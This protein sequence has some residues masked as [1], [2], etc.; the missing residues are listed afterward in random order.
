MSNVV[1][2][3]LKLDSEKFES[4]KKQVE[5]KRLSALAGE[6]VVFEIAGLTQS[7]FEEIQEMCTSIDFA[8][9]E[10]NV[11]F[12]KMQLESLL[13]GVVSPDLKNP[14]LMKR[15]G[16]VTPYDFIKKFLTPG[17]IS[18][19]YEAISDLS[20]FGTDAIEDVKKQ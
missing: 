11:D 17:E 16:S 14:E 8:T 15:F 13:K 20:G 6:S 1:D 19:L 5:I 4:A 18:S 2:I 9:K 12:S 7:Q 3:L 10:T